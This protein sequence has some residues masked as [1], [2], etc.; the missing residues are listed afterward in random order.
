MGTKEAQWSIGSNIDFFNLGLELSF[1]IISGAAVKQK[2]QRD[3]L[4]LR[5]GLSCSLFNLI[6][7]LFSR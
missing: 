6:L 5:W 3:I 2:I 1:F 4:D 7:S